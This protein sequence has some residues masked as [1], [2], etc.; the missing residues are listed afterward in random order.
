MGA[1]GV[2]PSGLAFPSLVREV[3]R[4]ADE[5]VCA[6]L[7]V[8]P[9]SESL[10][11]ALPDSARSLASRCV[12]DTGSAVAARP[13]ALS[14]LRSSDE[15]LAH[16]RL[17]RASS[18][19]GGSPTRALRLPLV[20]FLPN[21]LNFPD[22]SHVKDLTIGMDITCVI[23]STNTL[24]PRTRVPSA[25][26]DEWADRVPETNRAAVYRVMAHQ[27]SEGS[28]ARWNLLLH[29]SPRGR[30]ATPALITPGVLATMPLTPRFSL[31]ECHGLSTT[32][33][34]RVI[35]YFKAS[36]VNSILS[37]VD[38]CAPNGLGVFLIDVSYFQIIGP[39]VEL[40]APAED[41]AHAYK[42]A[43]LP[44]APSK[45][46]TI[47]LAPPKGPALRDQP[48]GSA[49]AP[50]YWGRVNHFIQHVL[51]RVFGISLFIYA[52]DVFAVEP[53]ATVASAR[54]TF[55]AVCDVI[56]PPHAPRKDQIPSTSL[57]LLW[58]ELVFDTNHLRA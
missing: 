38:T 37:A 40:R 48:Y 19:P 55:K 34:Y 26:H 57:R 20:A 13:H 47:A 44:V 2:R 22:T 50:S 6:A 4:P 5:R 7:K 45:F 24:N 51:Q 21:G 42:T 11:S 30:F 8:F 10:T 28:L 56:G 23:P 35:D 9:A 33:K 41:F 29:E 58:G 52:D 15:G 16:R 17:S 54:E 18:V 3:C 46:V 43:G 32:P 39:N 49:R 1:T 36:G 31:A 14:V 12:S 27:G 53:L 25:S